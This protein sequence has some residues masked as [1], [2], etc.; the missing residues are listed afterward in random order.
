LLG[1]VSV[2]RRVT[3]RLPYPLLYVLS[4]PAAWVAFVG[5]VWPYMALRRVPGLRKLAERIPM[6]Q[7]AE[8]PFGV[9]VNDQFDRFSAP[10]ENRYKK[11]QVEGWLRRAGLVDIRVTANSGWVASGR[12]PAP[13]P[14]PG[15]R[16]SRRDGD[17]RRNPLAECDPGFDPA[18]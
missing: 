16:G 13:V 3:T 2:I 6:R 4:Y 17:A 5:F 11:S 1:L 14:D 15:P 7:Y 9:C 10:I 8:Y 12:K 18:E